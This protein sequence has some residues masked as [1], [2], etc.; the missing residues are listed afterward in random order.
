MAKHQ[1]KKIF[2]GMFN[3]IPGRLLFLDHS[4]DMHCVLW[5]FSTDLRLKNRKHT[6][7]R[8]ILIT[9]STFTGLCTFNLIKSSE[10][11]LCQ[12]IQLWFHRSEMHQALTCLN[13]AVYSA[14]MYWLRVCRKYRF[15]LMHT[16]STCHLAW[17]SSSWLPVSISQKWYS[18][19]E[20]QHALQRY[21]YKRT[22]VILK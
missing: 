9:F 14:I 17:F 5:G 11:H 2:L 6:R 15:F 13:L 7:R 1:F 10:W 22:G 8:S 16:I 20:I 3:Q 18:L 19:V 4:S 21:N 12:R